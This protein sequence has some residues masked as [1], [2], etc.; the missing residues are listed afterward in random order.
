VGTLQAII[1]FCVLA[2]EL[3]SRYRLTL[4]GGRSHA[5]VAEPVEQPA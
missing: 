2:G 4:G 3:F 1:L 5:A